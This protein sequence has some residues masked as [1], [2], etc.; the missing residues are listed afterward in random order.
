MKFH[1]QCVYGKVGKLSV[2]VNGE[3]LYHAVPDCDLPM[4][5]IEVVPTRINQGENVITFHSEK[6]TYILSHVVIESKLSEVEFP[7]YYFDLS[8]EEFQDIED[9]KF[10]VR[11]AMSFVD[12]VAS[13]KG[14]IVVNGHRKFFDTKELSFTMDLTD[15][16]VKGSNSVKI[17]PRK[18]IEVRELRVDLV[19]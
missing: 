17:K 15:D 10:R 14:Q 8:N 5:P 19:E 1:P 6:G 4:V 7:T 13:K 16:I 18:T 9:E 11:L 12:V 2:E 3:V